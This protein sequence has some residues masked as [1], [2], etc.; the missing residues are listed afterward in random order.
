LEELLRSLN[1]K[2][3]DIDGLFLAKSEVEALKEGSRW[4][5]V[6]KL[7]TPGPFSVTFLK[8]TMRFA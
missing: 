2:G 3:E 8:K 7:L 1:L 5:A 4:M 6:M